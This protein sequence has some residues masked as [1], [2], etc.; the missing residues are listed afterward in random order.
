MYLDKVVIGSRVAPKQGLMVGF[1]VVTGI[2]QY[3]QPERRVYEV[4]TDFGNFIKFTQDEFCEIYTNEIYYEWCPLE[5]KLE[6]RNAVDILEEH[7]NDQ[8]LNLKSA[9]EDLKERGTI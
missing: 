5:D 8:I 4:L 9:L 3:S 1:G 7:I 6:E 2:F